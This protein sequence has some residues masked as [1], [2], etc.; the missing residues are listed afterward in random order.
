MDIYER[1]DDMDADKAETKAARILH[2]L[3]FTKQ[4]MLKKCKDFS[5]MS[6]CLAFGS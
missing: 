6:L 3:G 5:G 2:G 4:M 1:L